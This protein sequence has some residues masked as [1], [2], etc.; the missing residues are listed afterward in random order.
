[1][2]K[3]KCVASGSSGN[4]YI[5]EADGEILI[6]DAGIS[7]K[8]LLGALGYSINGLVGCLCTHGHLDHLKSA[9]DLVYLSVPV[10]APFI[11]HSKAVMKEQYGGFTVTAFALTDIYGNWCH[12]NGDGTDC[13]NYGFRIKHKDLGTLLYVTDTKLIKYRFKDLDHVLIGINYQDEYITDDFKYGHV[14]RGHLELKTAC[15]FLRVCES[16]RPLQT[17]LCGHLSD[18][19]ADPNEVVTAVMKVA[20]NALVCVAEPSLEVE[21]RNPSICPF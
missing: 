18:S 19:S 1:M 3:I 7:R 2:A 9:K 8:D 13:P 16:N 20:R 17:V 12:T 11:D 21:L 5:L 6:L 15:E 10:F 4:C 14:K